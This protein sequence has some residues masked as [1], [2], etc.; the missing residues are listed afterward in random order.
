MK[1]DERRY[2]PVPGAALGLVVYLQYLLDLVDAAVDGAV[3]DAGHHQ[4]L[5]LLRI[6]IQLLENTD[7]PH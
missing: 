2:K 3:Q 7:N 4:P 1:R 6:N 5:H